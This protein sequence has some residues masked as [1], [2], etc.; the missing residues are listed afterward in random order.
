MGRSSEEKRVWLAE[1]IA[2]NS[3]SKKLPV[4]FSFIGFSKRS[5]SVNYLG[6]ISDRELID[7][8]YKEAD[9][10]IVTSSREGFPLVIMEA[11]ANSCV[12]ISTEV[13][14]ISE[15]IKD[16]SNGFLVKNISEEF[17][18]NSFLEILEMLVKNR[19]LKD[20]ISKNAYRYASEN[21]D[22]DTFNEKYRQLLT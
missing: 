10:L 6:E 7:K 15:H 16:K 8:S 18:V 14:G 9:I 2:E 12:V 19:G 3:F 22:L 20:E 4:E 21:F 13:G 5:D 1:K 11:M 17:I